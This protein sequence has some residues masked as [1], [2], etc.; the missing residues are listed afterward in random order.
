[1]DGPTGMLGDHIWD[2]SAGDMRSF[3]LAAAKQ[4]Q[5]AGILK[6]A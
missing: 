2:A 3:W 4:R 5:D 1:M 6:A